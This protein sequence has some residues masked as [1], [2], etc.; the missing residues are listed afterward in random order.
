MTL[1]KVTSCP[2][3]T[4]AAPSATPVPTGAARS[5]E[6]RG[7]SRRICTSTVPETGSAE[8]GVGIGCPNASHTA[9]LTCSTSSARR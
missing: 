4:D 3:L 2:G 7:P 1:S 8:A 5:F 6:P 9:L